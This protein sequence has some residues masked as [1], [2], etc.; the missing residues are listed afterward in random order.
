MAAA[1]L[2]EEFDNKLLTCS[3][4]KGVYD[5]P[6]TLPCHHTFCANCLELWRKGQRRFTCPTCRQQVK[7]R[8]PD[9]SSFPSSFYI[10]NLLDFRALHNSS[11]KR[12]RASCGMCESDASIEGT[13]GDCKL[14][15]CGN[16]LTGHGNCPA[17]KDHYIIAWNE[18]NDPSSMLRVNQ[19]QYCPQHTDQRRTFYCQPCA[20]LMCQDCVTADHKP[21]PNHD[22]Q[23]VGLVAQKYVDELQTLVGKSQD[24]ADALKKTKAVVGNELTIISTN[25][26]IVK[27]EI[28]EHF[29]ELRAK[30]DK[31]EQEVTEKL[32]KMEETQKEPLVKEEKELEERLQS[33]EEDRKFC[34]D[35]LS[36]GNDVEI[37]TLR[38]Q[39][40]DRLDALSS[41]QIQHHSLKNHISF[42]PT[43]NINCELSLTCKPLV[44]TDPPVASLPTTIIFIPNEG[45]AL[46]TNPLITVTSPQGQHAQLDASRT[47]EG[48]FQA[49][50][51]PKTVGKHEVGVT[52][53][54]GG[55]LCP[56][57]SVH[58]G[59]N[60]PVL[61]FGQEL[62][63]M[64][65]DVAVSGNRLYVADELVRNIQVF[66]LSGNFCHSFGT[67]SAPWSLSV[68]TDGTIVV[69]T[70]TDV[71]KYSQSGEELHKFSTREYCTHPGGLAVLKDGRIVVTDSGKHCIFLFEANG[72]L[73]KQLGGKG[74]AEGEFDTPASVC[75]DRND[76]IIVSDMKNFRVQV[77][78]KDLNFQYQFGQEGQEPQDMCRP[79][80]VSADSKGNIV[81]VNFNHCDRQGIQVY[82][83]DG[84]WVATFSS[85]ITYH[86]RRESC[87]VAVTEDGHVFVANSQPLCIKKYRYL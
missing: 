32:V 47:N 66:D 74:R 42:L 62:F 13:C 68:H 20:K 34:T 79:M 57:L 45:Q 25:C 4:C 51:R 2:L 86:I 43:V 85:D 83:S 56:T 11:I 30:L 80:R 58:V 82:R 9:V 35:F 71:V 6:R 1:N 10:N 76:N 84:T 23:E 55:R 26:Q 67:P 16:C 48:A 54:G 63:Y 21:G 77:F 15:L 65:L 29:S 64:P 18:L 72:T 40:G 37:I 41:S 12:P 59:S 69:N 39:L 7:L 17:L 24:S 44:I 50:W 75:V 52:M 5:N 49:V 22:P 19:T 87:G 46:E 28:Q 8:G 38:K 14:L 60:D 73:V 78:D 70:V 81:L 53:G 33:T 31:E 36:R 3:I 61:N 27:K